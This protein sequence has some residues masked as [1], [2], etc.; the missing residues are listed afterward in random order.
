MK[1][2]YLIILIILLAACKGKPV[3]IIKDS[4]LYYTCSMHPQVMKPNPGSC[5]ICGMKMIAVKKSNPANKDEIIL[6]D[7]QARL[8]NISVDTIREGM[9]GGQL[10]LTATIN[11]DQTKIITISSR[12]M[13][14]I[15]KLYFKAE[16]DYVNRGD[17]LYDLYSEDL[18]NAKKEYLLAIKN[19]PTLDNSVIDFDQL[20][21]SAKNKLLLWGLSEVQIQQL[22][23]LKDAGTNTTFYST[24][25]GY[26]NQLDVK[27]GDY[28]MEGSPMIHLVDLSTVWAEA[29]VYSS[30]LS[31][32]ENNAV[33]EVRVPD[34]EQTAFTGKVAFIN[35]ELNPGTRI[36]LIR[37]D[38]PNN[39]HLLK[40]GMAAYV[41]LKKRVHNMLSLPVNSVLRD[42]NSATVWLKTGAH[43][44]KSAMVEVGMESENRIEITSGLRNHD[45]VV[46]TG[47]Y[48]LNSEY[49]FKNGANPMSGMKM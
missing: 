7:E 28:V 20:I 36:N 25:N 12:V 9:L 5:P 32:I 37:V 34:L 24:A 2:K 17:K 42:G 43:S 49:I 18:N 31:Y 13:G 21:R 3:K 29:Q 15:E 6:D 44:Y 35:S 19:R 47:A 46:V 27:E 40:P 30:E 1:P 4:G 14:Q 38:M 39:E 26:I 41:I 8:A 10:V 33:A 22:T 48:L 16:G 23:T 45:V 11:F